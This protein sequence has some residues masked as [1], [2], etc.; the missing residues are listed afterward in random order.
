MPPVDSAAMTTGVTGVTCGSCGAQAAE[1]A[2]FCATCG[3]PLVRRGDERRVVTV[4]FADLVGFT[5]MSET[6]DPEAVK[7][8]VDRCFHRLA[9]DIADFGGRVDKILGD[10]ILALFGAPV[11][12]E[13]D[14]ERAVRA[15]LRMQETLKT[16]AP[17][18][19]ASE[20]RMRVGI[21]TGEV[22]VGALRAGGDWTA[23]GDVVN[24]AQRLQTIAA[25]GTV[26]V[27]ADTHTA[28]RDCV[29]FVD[30]GDV[31]AKGRETPVAAWIAEEALAPPGHRPRRVDA[32]LVGRDHELALL[33]GMV[34][35]AV[36]KRRAAMVV[37]VAEA[38]MGK[39]RLVEEV[40][41]SAA[42][43]HDAS[44]LEGRCVPYGEANVWWP[45]AEA[46]RGSFGIVAGAVPA[47]A[48]AACV[49]RIELAMPAADKEEVERVAN[50]LLHLLG[51]ATPLRSIEPAR[52]REEVTR[53]LINYVEAWAQQRPVVVVLSDLHWADDQVLA[54]GDALLE[55][56][57]NLPV[58]LLCTSRAGLLDRW[59]PAQG[60]HNQLVLHLDALD[61]ADANELLDRL[62]E[63][64]LETGLREVLLDRSGGNPFFLE[65]LVS[66]L[67]EG[68]GGP[69]LPHT[70]RGLVAARLDSLPR[71]ER[72]VLECAAIL[73]KHFPQFALEIMASKDG[74]GVDVQAA[75]DGLV[76]KDLITSDEDAGWFAFRSDLV[77]EVAYGTLTKSSRV[78]GHAGVGR[79]LEAH[80][81]R[82]AA[83]IDRTAHHFAS[84]AGMA[85]EVGL[86]DGAP[87]DLAS[88]ALHW[89]DR[90][91]ELAEGGELHDSVIRLTTTAVELLDAADASPEQRLRFLL[92]RAKART[93]LRRLFVAE[94][95]LE[96][97]GEVAG[98]DR[99]LQARVLVRRAD[100]DQK[101]GEL[102]KS[103]DT[104]APAIEAFREAG[105]DAGTAEAL[106]VLGISHLF[107]GNDAGASPIFE[108]AMEHYRAAGDRRGEA[109]AIQNNAWA[110]YSGGNIGAAES[111]VEA[112]VT[113]F[114]ELGDN[115]GLAWALGLLA[116]IRYHQG[117]FEEA[118]ELCDRILSEAEDRGDPWARG[119]ML[120]LSGMLR[121]WTG[122]TNAA[123]EPTERACK[124]FREMG[125]WY[126]ALTAMGTLSRSLVALGRFDE[127][128]VVL[129]ESVATADATPNDTGMQFAEIQRATSAAQAGLPDRAPASLPIEAVPDHAGEIGFTDRFIAEGLLH[130]QR[131]DADAGRVVLERMATALG[132]AATGYSQSALALARVSTGDVDGARS[133]L[134]S[135]Q[136]MASATYSDRAAAAI[137][138]LLVAAR[139][140]DSAGADEALSNA[141]AI[142]DAT[143]DRLAKGLVVLASARA[144]E[145]LGRPVAPGLGLE[146]AD[147]CPG[148]DTAFRL[149]AGL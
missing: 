56:V 61:R 30:L 36:R 133:T 149:A 105:D 80:D 96:T 122:R 98:D 135:M 93:S 43:D 27:G 91:V 124:L 49:E 39:T 77:R 120:T 111:R 51:E 13:D 65:E 81:P 100:L 63:G 127:A 17:G 40:A 22:L 109:W 107:S 76:D 123:I 9:A 46:L 140:G 31:V 72:D 25:P 104:L 58:L 87:P 144:D 38:G 82:S 19:G 26:V 121:L 97:A 37:V 48:R 32:P 54:L 132:E 28:T 5:T 45:V 4:L 125:D 74:L 24:T 59:Q 147:S 41:S 113:I 115:G 3:Q 146:W 68:A 89:L 75:V 12:H 103:I 94:D 143:D 137:A 14:A 134:A 2:A 136:G 102:A 55:R 47:A 70:L 85:I 71:G 83:D 73:G 139:A 117:R 79:W 42:C 20:L 33:T 129:D 66:L 21:N 15:A 106:V 86:P 6:T 84:A 138:A 108:E 67:G 126:G 141:R 16:W 130:L 88:K 110:A 44:V 62:T 8:L 95:D 53:S 142:V 116:Y 90:S 112:S 128:F 114:K 7:N 60:R 1:G 119:M 92:S 131:G 23:M 69:E 11:A 34:D 57:A 50:G 29:R 101:R 145:A 148:W 18:V 52:V 64:V 10:A 118:E 99:L 78:L 35:S